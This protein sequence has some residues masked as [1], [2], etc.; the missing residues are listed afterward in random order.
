MSTFETHSVTDSPSIRRWR[1]DL[2]TVVMITV[3]T[4]AIAV[5]G[6]S[7]EALFQ[8]SR[9]FEHLQLDE[10]PIVL[11]VLALCLMWFAWRRHRETLMML[12]RRNAAERKLADL[13]RENRRLGQQNVA[14]QE[15]ERKHLARELHDE[16]GQ[17]LNAIKTYAVKIQAAADDS[18]ESMRHAATSVLDHADRAYEAV[19]KLI[20]QL[21]PAGLDELGLKA[22]LEH[23]IEQTQLRLPHV[24]IDVR[25]EGELDS[26]DETTSLTIF[27]L[28]QEGFTN[29]IKHAR[30]ERVDIHVVRET[31]SDGDRVVFR[32]I[33]DGRGC[34]PGAPSVGVG[35]I[36]MRERVEMLG[37]EWRI[38]SSPGK[39]FAIQAKIP[40]RD[41]SAA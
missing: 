21:R 16:A 20:R 39:G 31:A 26:L 38:D 1:R 10:I 33:D 18:N 37:G 25:F 34:D 12:A 22:A 2:V 15:A 24:A 27:R 23:F 7:S 3:L 11:L 29:V 14:V 32:L 9:R 41:A 30:A 13:L 5:I 28:T 35:L 36:G 17:Y 19:R 6:D 8:A 4:G 40:L